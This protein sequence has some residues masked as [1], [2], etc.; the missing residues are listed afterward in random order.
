MASSDPSCRKI[1][2]PKTPFVH[3]DAAKDEL[4]ID[5]KPEQRDIYQSSIDSWLPCILLCR[6]FLAQL[7]VCKEGI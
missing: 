5:G 1:D 4:D 7:A 6:R 2:E 3:S